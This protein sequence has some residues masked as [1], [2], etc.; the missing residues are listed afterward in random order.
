MQ[1]LFLLT[2]LI[3][4]SPGTIWGQS[5]IAD[6]PWGH[7]SLEGLWSNETL[8]PF[9]RPHDQADREYITQE[10]ASAAAARKAAAVAMDAEPRTKKA[11]PPKKGGNVGGYNL[12]WLDNGT[13]VV[14][15][16]RSS[17]IVAP[18]NGRVPV[19]QRIL[20]QRDDDYRKSFEDPEVMSVWDR[21]ITRGVP[22]SMLPAGYN[23]YYRIVQ[24]PEA[25][26]IYY[27]MIHEARYIP[28]S[29]EPRLEH[30][31]FWNGQP[32]GY[33]EGSALI[34]KT[35]G[36]NNKGWI[37]TSFSQGRIKG[38][39]HTNRLEVTERFERIGDDTV[40]WQ[41]TVSDPEIYHSEWTVEIP[42]ERRSG[43]KIY[44][45]ACH[46]GNQAVGNILRGA[47]VQSSR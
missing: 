1:R 12:G 33:W 44:E 18:A 31:E 40:L 14:S 5:H 4:I 10:E 23:N 34:V 7:P 6:T 16:M 27:E 29:D 41:A 20:E 36:F 19:R 2:G 22:G 11:V 30:V 39:P 38:V 35:R 8:T 3:F 24:R 37:A 32:R 43:Q 25:V 15:T 13:T 21:C 42:L 9:E 26:L 17:Q 46:E 45:Y 28:L 47:R